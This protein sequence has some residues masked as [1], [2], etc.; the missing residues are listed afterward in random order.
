MSKKGNARKRKK[1]EST[2]PV[3]S[4][5]I[6]ALRACIWFDRMEHKHATCLFTR[7]DFV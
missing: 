3:I 2:K 1:L 7:F 6:Y 5:G 4:S